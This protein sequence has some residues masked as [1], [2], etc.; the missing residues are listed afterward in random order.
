MICNDSDWP[1]DVQSYQRNVE[2]DRKQFP[3]F[4]AAGANITPCA[5]WPGDPLEPPVQIGAE[6]PANVLILQNLR[7]PATLRPGPGSCGSLRR[8]GPAGDR[9]PGW[10]PELSLPG[11]LLRRG[12]HHDVP[13]LRRTSGPGPVLRSWAERQ[14]RPAGFAV[15]P[16]AKAA[17]AAFQHHPSIVLRW[18][19]CRCSGANRYVRRSGANAPEQCGYD[20]RCRA[21][22]PRTRV[23]GIGGRRCVG[24]SRAV[25][26]DVCVCVCIATEGCAGPPG[27]TPGRGARIPGAGAGDT[28][29]GGGARASTAAAGTGG[30]SG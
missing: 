7:D 23:K 3:M 14:G 25:Q 5:F 1:E 9:R 15:R 19:D 29:V 17:V 28:A 24:C 8:P 26:G 11:Q 20:G 27:K 10:A 22:A 13:G 30:Q 12:D 6:G 18:P 4:G 2:A 16:D 21:G